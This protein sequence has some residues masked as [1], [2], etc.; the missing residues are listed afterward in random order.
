LLVSWAIPKGLPQDRKTNHLAIQTEDHPLE[1]AAFEG[2]IP[3]G[4][5]GAGPVKIWDRDTYEC[6]KWTDRE[7]K[8]VLHGTR[9]GAADAGDAG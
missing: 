2:Q 9:A 3:P 7:A 6:E 8:V 1:Y 5:Y 4:Q